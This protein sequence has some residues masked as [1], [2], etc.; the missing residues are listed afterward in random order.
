MA[1]S[2]GC[3]GPQIAPES[4]LARAPESA[5]PPLEAWA[6]GHP[7]GELEVFVLP[8]GNGDCILIRAP[9]GR[10][11]LIDAGDTEVRAPGDPERLRR[12][13]GE[14]IEPPLEALVLTHPDPAH[15][16]SAPW[17]LREVGVGELVHHGLPSK[18][19]EDHKVVEALAAHPP[20]TLLNVAEA[21]EAVL[22]ILFAPAEDFAAEVLRVP[23]YGTRE[24]VD[25][26]VVVVRV[27]FGETVWL[28]MSD[29]TRAMERAL[30][31]DPRLAPRVDCDFLLVGSHGGS[32]AASREFLAR[33]TPQVAAI[34]CGRPNEGLNVYEGFPRASTVAAIESWVGERSGPERS[35]QVCDDSVPTDFSEEEEAMIEALSA[36]G[37][38]STSPMI[39]SPSVDP[40]QWIQHEL[41]RAL[42]VTEGRRTLRFTSD[43]R[44]VRYEEGGDR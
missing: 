23:G 31:A 38:L 36:S 9:G 39:F 14:L 43:G 29:S 42:Y 24:R 3:P 40:G 22:P 17:L 34:S 26:D 21:T 33:A 12:Q 6:P 18:L 16:G 35:V 30:I 44:E 27:R 28:F 4:A 25:E 11:L 8:A 1:S 13:L 2:S 32:A 20:Q 5:R 41:T 7:L 19:K 37:S 10:E 15:L